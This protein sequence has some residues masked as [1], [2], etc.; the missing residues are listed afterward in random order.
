[1]REQTLAASEQFADGERTL[2]Y[3]CDKAETENDTAGGVQV[4]TMPCVGMLPPSFVDY[5]T[6]R[7]LA[8]KVELAG[9]SGGDCYFRLGVDWTVQRVTGQ[10]DPY[11]RK[12]VPR[13]KV[14][15]RLGKRVLPAEDL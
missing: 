3:A 12:R 5:V 6:S 8:D 9:C 14:S 11:L 10:R 7:N 13:D 1:L 2:V 15:V 4:I